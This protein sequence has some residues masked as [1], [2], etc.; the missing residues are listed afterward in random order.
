MKTDKP[1]QAILLSMTAGPII[2]GYTLL[3]KSLGLTNLTAIESISMFLQREPSY[4]GGSI[5][6]LVVIWSFLLLYY[7]VNL[8]GTAYFPLKGML[9]GMTGESLL[10]N[11]AGVLGRDE[12]LIQNVSGNYVHASAAAIA[13]LWVGFLYKK[14]LYKDWKGK[15]L[16]MDKPLLAIMVGWAGW[17][18]AEGITQI[19]KY[20][21]ITSL[22]TMEA[23]SLMRMA[24]PSLILGFLAALGL[25]SWCGLIIYYSAKLWRTDYFPI[26]A[27][28]ISLTCYS[29]IIHIFGVLG[30]ND[31][32]VQGAGGVLV[33]AFG[34]TVGGMAVGFLMK[35]TLFRYG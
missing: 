6:F 29:L 21:G 3:M 11:I 25:G 2:E 34:V 17:P 16:T 7:S 8:W 32:L 28:L 9:I 5:G 10:F 1:L 30:G 33:H 35:K 13:G 20:F 26:K 24:K 12:R 22:S 15:S 18:V 14:Y 19:A 31:M 4:T 27:A 23:A